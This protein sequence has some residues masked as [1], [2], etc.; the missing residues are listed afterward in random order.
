MLESRIRDA[1]TR[2]EDP[3]HLSS[4]V[5]ALIDGLQGGYD[6]KYKRIVSTCKHF[7]GYDLETEMV[8]IDINL[9]PKSHHRT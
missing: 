6:R 4:Y 9:T 5:H 1:K 7:V 8:I 2:G 3:Y